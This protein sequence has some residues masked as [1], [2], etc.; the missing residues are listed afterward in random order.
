MGKG[1]LSETVGKWPVQRE[2]GRKVFRGHMSQSPLRAVPARK[3]HLFL[4]WQQP[5]GSRTPS[6]LLLTRT[7]VSAANETALALL[8]SIRIPLH[9]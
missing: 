8:G 4:T 6:H 7:E 1:H 2:W 5:D 3:I 9:S